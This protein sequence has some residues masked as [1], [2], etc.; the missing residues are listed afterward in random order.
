MPR[1][2][3][4]VPSYN[5]AQ[6][7]D[8]CVRSVLAQDYTDYELIVVNDGSEDNTGELISS[9][10]GCDSRVVAVDRQENLGRHFTRQ[11]AV[12]RASGDYVLF[13][14]SDDELMPGFLGE[15]NSILQ[16]DPVDVLHFGVKVADCGVGSDEA[17]Q[18]EAYVN[19]PLEELTGDSILSAPPMEH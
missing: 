4:C 19:A 12:D 17:G 13:L 6:Y 7:L 16:I 14:D 18:F 3:I 15:L 1:F 2:S 5:N 10:A 9:L 11:E 8:G